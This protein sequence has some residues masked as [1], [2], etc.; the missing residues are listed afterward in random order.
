MKSISYILLC[1]LVVQQ[2]LGANNLRAASE[3]NPVDAQ[4]LQELL[5]YP[6]VKSLLQKSIEHFEASIV[7]QKS[8]N[9]LA[10]VLNRQVENFAH[11]ALDLTNAEGPFKNF[12]SVANTTDVKNLMGKDLVAVF[13]QPQVQLKK[14]LQMMKRS[15]NSNGVGIN[16]ADSKARGILV[17]I[18]FI[19]VA[20]LLFG[21]MRMVDTSILHGPVRLWQL[22]EFLVAVILPLFMILWVVLVIKSLQ[23]KNEP[24]IN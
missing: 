7:E 17:G 11:N 16:L 22:P 18:V 9:D 19:S 14:S 24:K 21:G 10:A 13:N 5:Q 1:I 15:I 2:S 12:E 3:G 20:Y 8:K 23:E 6:Q 4:N